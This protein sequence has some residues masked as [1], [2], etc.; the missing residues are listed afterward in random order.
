ME[1]DSKQV[2][3]IPN[4]AA[5]Q[6]EAAVSIVAPADADLFE[7]VTEAPRQPEDL[8]VAHVAVDPRPPEDIERG[9]SIEEL[10]AALGVT[11]VVQADDGVHPEREEPCAD[12]AV[13][14]LR[15][16]DPRVYEGA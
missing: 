4:V 10:K 12:L 7:P 13:S 16:L 15:D 14:W 11:D 9:G 3:E 5:D 6:I 8:D 1:P 2:D